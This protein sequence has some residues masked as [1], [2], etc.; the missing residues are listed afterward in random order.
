MLPGPQRPALRL[1]QCCY[2]VTG[3]CCWALPLFW[4]DLGVCFG[5]SLDALRMFL[6]F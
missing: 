1:Q 2:E 3:L 5:M 4:E 6:C